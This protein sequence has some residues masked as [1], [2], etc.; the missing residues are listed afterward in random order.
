MLNP[1]RLVVCIASVVATACVCAAPAHASSLSVGTRIPISAT[2]FALPIEIIDA[3][4]VVGW[5]FS[6]TYDAADVQVNDGCDPFSGDIYC[7]LMTQAV[8]EGDFFASGTPFNLLNPGFIDLDPTTLNQTGLLFGVTGTFGG[9]APFP[10][11]SGTLAFVE[12]TV[13]GTGN[14]AITVNGS[15]GSVSTVPEPG[16]LALFATGLLLPAVRR[17]RTSH[18]ASSRPV[19]RQYRLGAK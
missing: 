4:D 11:G 7:S 16:T 6:L 10:S 1:R 5:E 18:R 14:R 12:F 8:T 2:T 17:L 15:V 19:R 13:L 9:S 3:L